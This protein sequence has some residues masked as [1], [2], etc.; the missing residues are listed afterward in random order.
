MEDWLPGTFSGFSGFTRNRWRASLW[1]FVYVSSSSSTE[2]SDRALYPRTQNR[3]CVEGKRGTYPGTYDILLGIC[4]RIEHLFSLFLSL[5]LSFIY[6][7]W[8]INGFSIIEERWC[9]LNSMYLHTFSVNILHL[10]Y[11][12][13]TLFS[14]PSAYR[15]IILQCLRVCQMWRPGFWSELWR[16]RKYSKPPT[17]EP[18]RC[19][20]SRC[21]LRACS[22]TSYGVSG[23]HC[24]TCAS[25]SGCAF[26]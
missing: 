24:H 16:G 10:I 1:V 23:I 11:K 5:K 2:V 9:L 20:L 4:G 13:D 3:A 26:V 21:K 8:S 25:S 15:W 22:I 7:H 12:V 6:D 17:Y 18:S 19:G 14:Q